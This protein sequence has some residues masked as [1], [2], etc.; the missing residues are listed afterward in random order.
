MG[1]ETERCDF[2]LKSLF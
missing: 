2:T 1:I